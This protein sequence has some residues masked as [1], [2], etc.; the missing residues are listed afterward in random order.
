MAKPEGEA[1]HKLAHPSGCVIE[2]APAGE[3]HQSVVS[4]RPG[5][6]DIRWRIG[7]ELARLWWKGWMAEGFRPINGNEGET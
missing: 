4:R 1:S 7:R 6:A 2:F 5:R 3:H